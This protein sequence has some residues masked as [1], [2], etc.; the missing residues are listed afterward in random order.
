[1]NDKILCRI[2]A[3]LIPFGNVAHIAHKVSEVLVSPNVVPDVGS[4]VR[5]VD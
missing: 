3:D 5:I 1:M 2:L 4:L